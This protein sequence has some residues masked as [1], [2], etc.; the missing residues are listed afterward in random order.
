M[1]TEVNTKSRARSSKSSNRKAPNSQPEG[2]S[3]Q[4]NI[5]IDENF[6]DAKRV[7]NND[8]AYLKPPKPE[9][10]PNKFIAKLFESP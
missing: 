2:Q 8:V 4:S 5:T 10:A 6:F 7:K 1:E 9:S 3:S